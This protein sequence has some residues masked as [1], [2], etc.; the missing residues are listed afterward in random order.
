MK[1]STNSQ[2]LGKRNSKRFDTVATLD[3]QAFKYENGQPAPIQD[4][5]AE[6]ILGLE[7]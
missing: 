4:T 1:I 7:L 5:D 2:Y 6:A 3:R